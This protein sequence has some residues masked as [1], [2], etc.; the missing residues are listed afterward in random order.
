MDFLLL[1]LWGDALRIILMP[2]LKKYW[3]FFETPGNLGL[4]FAP[5]TVR[6]AAFTVKELLISIALIASLVV[7]LLPSIASVRREAVRTR[8]LSTLRQL[9]GA[10][11]LYLGDHQQRFFLRETVPGGKPWPVHLLPYANGDQQVFR[12]PASPFAPRLVERTYRFNVTRGGGYYGFGADP[13]PMFGK[14][15]TAVKSPA[16][17][18]AIVDFPFYTNRPKDSVNIRFAATHDILWWGALDDEATYQAWSANYHGS[19][20]ANFLFVDGHVE[21][22][23]RPVPL[24]YYDYLN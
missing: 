18:V 19:P 24:H 23:P 6:S 17:T 13:Y 16:T 10:L 1:P 8:C 20:R 4:M 5:R 12:C 21:A 11:N 14:S 2:K 3:R 9:G 7:L 15:V 22:V